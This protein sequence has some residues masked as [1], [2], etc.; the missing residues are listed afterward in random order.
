[1]KLS[2]FEAC[3]E[4]IKCRV[5]GNAALETYK[6]NNGNH[7]GVRCAACGCKDPIESGLWWLSQN[8]TKDHVRHMKHDSK[9]VWDEWGGHC[10][11]CGKS[12]ALCR[13]LDISLQAQHVFPV[14]F[15]GEEDGPLVPICARCQEMTRPL[16]LETRAVMNAL[17][18]LSE[19]K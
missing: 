4:E 12:D 11:F 16:L 17:A 6:P 19:I 13:M 2:G 8:G 3:K 7:V 5:C 15:G 18:E 9:K 14:M 1:M 10:S